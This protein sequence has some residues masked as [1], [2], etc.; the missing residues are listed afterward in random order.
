VAAVIGTGKNTSVVLISVYENCNSAVRILS[1]IL[2]NRGQ[3]VTE[4]YFKHWKNNYF[5]PPSVKEKQR[6]IDVVRGV[7]PDIVAFSVRCSAYESVA[8]HLTSIL[9]KEIEAFYLWGGIHP[10]LA[11]ERC[12]RYAD[13]VIRGEGEIPI[14]ILPEAVTGRISLSDVPN[15]WTGDLYGN[16]RNPITAFVE[17]LDE[18]PFRDSESPDKFYIDG[19]IMI[20]GDPIAR[21]AFLS[22]TASRGCPYNCTFCYNNALRKAMPS[23]GSKYYRVRSPENVVEELARVKKMNPRLRAIRFDDNIFPFRKEWVD[24]FCKL[25][26]E[27]V[28]LP[29]E[30]LVQ[31]NV[32]SDGLLDKLA[33]AGLREVTTGIQST[34]MVNRKIYGRNVHLKKIME[35]AKAA[36]DAGLETHYQVLIDNPLAE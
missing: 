31:P 22:I 3:K 11:P 12:L 25:Y 18:I 2:R 28:G 20:E 35:F 32:L 4:V 1:A 34:E 23:I 14:A 21:S 19:R 17:D 26:P 30:V 24:R 13:G 7:T 6:L 8:A 33:R 10:T 15:L 5:E 36:G 29:F 9:R 27:K 16:V